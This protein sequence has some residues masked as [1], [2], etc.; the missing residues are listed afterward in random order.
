MPAGSGLMRILLVGNR[1][2]TDVLRLG[3]WVFRLFT[4]AITIQYSVQQNVFSCTNLIPE[5]R[6]PR[7]NVLLYY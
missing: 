7:S 4:T 2:I 3:H 6:P 1:R 5:S